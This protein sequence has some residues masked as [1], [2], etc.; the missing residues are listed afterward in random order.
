MNTRPG[1]IWSPGMWLN[2]EHEDVELGRIEG[3]GMAAAALRAA[4]TPA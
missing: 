3:L 2:I 1:D 4:N